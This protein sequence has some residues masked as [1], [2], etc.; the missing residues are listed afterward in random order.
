MCAYTH[1]F[2]YMARLVPFC[3]FFGKLP[4]SDEFPS[5]KNVAESKNV[6]ADSYW[7]RHTPDV[8]STVFCW[9]RRRTES[10]AV[11]PPMAWVTHL[12]SEA[13][14]EQMSSTRKWEHRRG[15]HSLGTRFPGHWNL[16]VV[17]THH[18]RPQWSWPG[19]PSIRRISVGHFSLPDRPS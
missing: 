18:P 10:K 19:V 14:E 13:R 16:R 1:E 9:L 15:A 6:G 5:H 7:G 4:P 11:W 12:C 2:V 8:C 17:E 3:S